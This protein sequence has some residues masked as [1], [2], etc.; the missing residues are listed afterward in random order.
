MFR[1]YA[2]AWLCCAYLSDY[3]SQVPDALSG[4]RDSGWFYRGFTLQEMIAPGHVLFYDRN[5]KHFGTRIDL[6]EELSE[7]TGIDRDVLRSDNP[8][9]LLP[10]ISVGKKMSWAA[11]RQTTRPEDIAY[12]LLGIFGVNMPLLYGEG[13]RAF[14]RL[15]EEILKDTTDS[16]LFAWKAKDTDRCRGILA[17][18]PAEFA[19]AR[20]LVPRQMV[21]HDPE[22]TLTNKGLRTDILD[23]H[24]RHLN[25][26]CLDLNLQDT[27]SQAS[28]SLGI[29][30]MA[31]ADNTYVRRKPESL[32]DMSNTVLRPAAYIVKDLDQAEAT[33]SFSIPEAPVRIREIRFKVRQQDVQEP[34]PPIPIR[35]D[36][37]KGLWNT[38]TQ[39]LDTRGFNSFTAFLQVNLWRQA[40][41]A[42][43]VCGFEM[44][45]RPWVCVS[46]PDEPIFAAAQ[47][48][49]TQRLVDLCPR[50]R[51]SSSL[52]EVE[53]LRY[54]RFE[55]SA[56]I[57][58][59]GDVLVVEST[60]IPIKETKRV[61]P[62]K[63]CLVM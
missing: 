14:I 43:I 51:A 38:R 7:I 41:Y 55:L 25:I 54:R 2:N 48:N 61:K 46:V 9:D 24:P 19:E 57:R 6:S 3:D 29:M 53:N 18:S 11:G 45:G 27:R 58:A 17:H 44:G 26:S 4:L 59:D 63:R 40:P 36:H 52:C 23:K 21:S 50:A 32:I 60:F 39:T 47:A 34:L 15:Q 35:G 16:T 12:C 37:M 49:N 62:A 5:W 56:T 10:R 13:D 22:Y 30:L 20:Y 31:R 42:V 1:W 8:P 33:V 28:E